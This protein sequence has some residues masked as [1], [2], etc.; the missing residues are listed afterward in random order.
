MDIN[1]KPGESAGPS[2][3]TK[4]ILGRFLKKANFAHFNYLRVQIIDY[5]D[6]QKS[7]VVN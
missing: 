2:L 3:L 4:E 5:I 1:G 6:T 7:A